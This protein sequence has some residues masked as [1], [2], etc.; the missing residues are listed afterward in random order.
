MSNREVVKSW[1]ANLNCKKVA[2]SPV[3]EYK[4]MSEE[5]GALPEDVPNSRMAVVVSSDHSNSLFTGVLSGI[6][7]PRWP[8]APISDTGKAADIETVDPRLKTQTPE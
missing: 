2:P 5:E 7:L 6:L 8:V 1:L 3:G 4:E